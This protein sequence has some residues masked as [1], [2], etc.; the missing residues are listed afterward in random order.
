MGEN[1]GVLCVT[2]GDEGGEGFAEKA[3]ESCD[4]V[5]GDGVGEGDMGVGRRW[6]LPYLPLQFP[7]SL[8]LLGGK[9]RNVVLKWEEV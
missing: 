6:S 8:H 1:F 9:R 5:R 7:V 4:D 3:G 2:R